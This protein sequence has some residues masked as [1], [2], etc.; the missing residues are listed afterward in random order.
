[1]NLRKIFVLSLVMGCCY[2]MR[3]EDATARAVQQ[4]VNAELAADRSDHTR[5]IFLEVDRKPKVTVEQ[6]VAQ[7]AK[8]DVTRVVKRNGHP[9]PEGQQRSKVEAFVH[10]LSAQA[11]QRQS[12][13]HDDKQAEALLKLLPVAFVW[14]EAGRNQETTTYHFKPDPKFRPPSREAQVFAAMEGSMT[15]NN[16]QHRIQELK[17][18]LIRDVDFG[19]GFLGRLK[20]GGSFEVHRSQVGPGIWDITETHIHILGH[21]LLFKSI[22]EVEDDV[23]TSWQR[24]PDD[25]TL[26][27]AVAA[28]MKK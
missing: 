25:V 14:T 19:W 24:E 23:K 13:A 8:A 16:G 1:M 9:V 21:A 7:T 15:V 10:D 28:V 27:Q 26:E 4:A 22:A 17:G 12:N 3:A 11:K 20:A 18:R 6:W 5:W 2:A